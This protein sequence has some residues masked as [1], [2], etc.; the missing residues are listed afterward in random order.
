MSRDWVHD[1]KYDLHGMNVMLAA[2]KM[3]K[4]PHW[5]AALN[6]GRAHRGK[7]EKTGCQAAA[8]LWKR[9]GR[10]QGA[11]GDA[12]VRFRKTT[13]EGWHSTGKGGPR[14]GVTVSARR[15]ASRGGVLETMLH[16]IVHVVHLSDMRAPVVN[17]VR[18]PH[19]MDFNLIMCHM[20]KMMWGFPL[21]PTQAGYSTGKGYRPSRRLEEWLHSEIKAGNPRIERWLNGCQVIGRGCGSGLR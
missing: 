14:Y 8:L 21:T 17:G 19:G 16:E 15:S 4:S 9:T 11:C 13:K 5:L 12:G 2:E 3:C 1:S 6:A 20:A 18:R 7:A 10:S